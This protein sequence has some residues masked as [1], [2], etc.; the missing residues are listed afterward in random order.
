[1]IWVSSKFRRIIHVLILCEDSDEQL[2]DDH[3]PEDV[4]AVPQRRQPSMPQSFSF[5]NQRQPAAGPRLP[6][7]PE[8]HSRKQSHRQPNAGNNRHR[9]VSSHANR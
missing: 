5:P 8:Q 4:Q 2:Y 6:S 1:M 3:E 7:Q 9:P